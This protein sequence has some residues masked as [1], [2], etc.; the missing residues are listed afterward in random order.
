MKKMILLLTATAALAGCQKVKNLTNIDF[1][2][3]YNHTVTLSPVPGYPYGSTLPDGGL[4]VP[5]GPMMLATGVQQYFDEYHAGTKNV[6]TCS[7]SDLDLRILSP[8]AQFFDFLDTIQVYIEAPAYSDVDPEVLVAY[9]YNVPKG[10]KVIDLVPVPGL[11]LKKYIVQD[12]VR[13]RLYT[14]INAVPMPQ[15]EVYAEGN[16]HMTVNPL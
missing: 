8:S 1:D 11:D 2:A 4:S 13:V 3:A 16:F 15:T 9:Q 14:H 7:L 6:V 5:I 12:S 10:Q